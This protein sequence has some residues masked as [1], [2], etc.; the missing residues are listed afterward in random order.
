MKRSVLSILLAFLLASCSVPDR[1][2]PFADQQTP[3]VPPLEPPLTEEFSAIAAP[4]F[5]TEEQQ[6]LYRLA[7]RLL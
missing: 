1:A 2:Q 7:A 5:L 6:D 3:T 4:D